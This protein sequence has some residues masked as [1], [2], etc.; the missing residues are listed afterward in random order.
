[1]ALQAGR[2]GARLVR[3]GQA[4]LDGPAAVLDGRDGR[5]A[6]PAIVAADLDDVRVGLGHA[7]GH[8]ANARLRDQLDADLGRRGHLRAPTRVLSRL[9]LTVL[10]LLAHKTAVSG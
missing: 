8:R 10:L 2:A 5:C 7:A 6:R 3:L 1:M 9:P 4:H